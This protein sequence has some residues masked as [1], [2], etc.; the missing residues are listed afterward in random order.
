MELEPALDL[1]LEAAKTILNRFSISSSLL[2]NRS[3]LIGA[4]ILFLISIFFISSTSCFFFSCLRLFLSSMLSLILSFLLAVL[5]LISA[6]LLNAFMN[7]KSMIHKKSTTN[8]INPA[9][10]ATAMFLF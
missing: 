1:E 4:L 7:G 5:F 9:N 8:P 2:M 3:G 10:T 6:I